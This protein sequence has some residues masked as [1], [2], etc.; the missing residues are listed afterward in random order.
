M[1]T[2]KDTSTVARKDQDFSVYQRIDPRQRI[3]WGAQ[4]KKITD[5]VD[6]IRD[7]R[8]RRKAKIEKNYRKQQEKLQEMGDYESPD[9]QQTAIQAG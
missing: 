1:A 7:D 3:D 9:L 8:A 5:T 6:K 2:I 4:A